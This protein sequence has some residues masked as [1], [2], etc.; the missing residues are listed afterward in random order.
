MKQL[1]DF[2]D[3]INKCSKCGLCQ[4]VCPI[5]KLTGNDCAVSKGKFVMLEGVL[6][7][8]LEL[9][10]TINKYL[11]MCLKCG[12]CAKFCPS[13]INVC[14]IF[15][16]AKYEYMQKS[17]E[18]KLS[19]LLFS[20]KIFDNTI[21]NIGRI[22]S[23]KRLPASEKSIKTL[24]FFKGCMNNLN[25]QSANALKKIMAKLPYT[26]IENNDLKCCGVPLYSAGELKR[27]EEV[28]EY[29]TNI[30]NETEYDY[31]L[32]DCASCETE[33][34]KYPRLNK[35]IIDF[36][37]FL[38]SQNIHFKFK[39]K[40]RVTFHKPCHY[41]K[42]SSITQLLNRCENIDYVEMPDYDECCGFSGQFAL[43]NRKLS[44]QLSKNKIK[45]AL[46]VSPDIILTTC[47]A[48][49]LGLKQGLIA[50][51]KIYSKKPKILNITEF[52]SYGNIIS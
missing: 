34:N 25:P 49:I 5:Y 51:K 2:T 20:E 4:A 13:G 45:N 3:E 38:V 27:Y 46:S 32:T 47:P 17:T 40:L 28:I 43:T 36:T 44:I 50:N 11:E 26:L 48:C 16:T 30:L 7:G 15:Q 19:N 29:N 33:L 52:L 31:I 14:D 6:K 21:K 18:G 1:N 9:S 41:D 37:E 35:P 12:K 42:Y 24:L 39:K 22:T 23:S 8:D 10:P